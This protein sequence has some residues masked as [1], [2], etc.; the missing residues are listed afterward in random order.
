[1]CK[2]F[3][4]V[5]SALVDGLTTL[6]RPYAAKLHDYL[7][8]DQ[9]AG[10]HTPLSMIENILGYEL[11]E[12]IYGDTEYFGDKWSKQLSD[13]DLADMLALAEK[14]FNDNPDGLEEIWQN[15]DIT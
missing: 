13:D 7:Y 5:K 6:D 2:I 4:S 8:K 10:I 3:E 14:W 1:M 12:A 11:L 15:L 9:S